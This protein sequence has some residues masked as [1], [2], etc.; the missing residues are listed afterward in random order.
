MQLGDLLVAALALIAVIAF[1][2]VWKANE[3]AYEE[4]FEDGYEKGYKD[5]LDLWELSTSKSER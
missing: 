2:F 1:Y 3:A 5:A 4:G